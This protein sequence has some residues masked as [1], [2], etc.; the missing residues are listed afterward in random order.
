MKRR[1]V[2][3]FDYLGRIPTHW[4]RRAEEMRA[5]SEDAQEP[6][7]TMMLRIAGDYDRGASN[8]NDRAPQDS[9]MFRRADVKPES[10]PETPSKFG[11]KLAKTGYL[12]PRLH[13][14][15]TV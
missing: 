14:E 13:F 5:L 8:A 7:R 9:I 15:T 1:S 6:V 12:K 4:R 10:L 3:N 11:R 2:A